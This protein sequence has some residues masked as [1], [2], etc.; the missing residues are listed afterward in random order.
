MQVDITFHDLSDA[1]DYS[2]LNDQGN[3]AGAPQ[4]YNVVNVLPNDVDV[5]FQICLSGKPPARR[6][7]RDRLGRRDRHLGGAGVPLTN[8]SGDLWQGTVTFAAGDNPAF[9]YKYKKDD[10]ATWESV[11]NRAV[12]LPTDGTTAVNLAA[13]SWDNTPMGCGMGA[14]LSENKVVCFQVCVARRRHHGRRLR[15]RRP[16]PADQLGQRRDDEPDLGRP[17]PGLRG[18]PRRHGGAPELRVQ[19]PQGR[20]RHL[21]E[22]GQ[23]HVHGGREQ[24]ADGDDADLRV[25]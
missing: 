24:P 23:P 12:A 13:D 11:G 14:N 7:L 18:L 10:C 20:L 9:E 16:R 5:T 8:V 21:G 2:G 25:G 3:G 15:H 6:G 1:T 4:Q 17:L 19:V 22:R